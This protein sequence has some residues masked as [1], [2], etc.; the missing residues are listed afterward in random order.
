MGHREQWLSKWIKNRNYTFDTNNRRNTFLYIYYVTVKSAYGEIWAAYLTRKRNS[1]FVKPL[2]TAEL[3]RRIKKWSS[4][5]CSDRKFRNKKIFAMLGITEEEV[6]EL[7]IEK[8]KIEKEE[9]KKR[10]TKRLERNTEII[11]LRSKGKTQKEIVL[12]LNVSLS[13]VKRVLRESR[14]IFL[15]GSEF[16]ITDKIKGKSEPP[17]FRSPTAE[18]LYSLYKEEQQAAPSNEYELALDKLQHSNR[19]IFIQGV[20]GSGKSTLIKEYLSSLSKSERKTVL[21][22][23]PTGKAA[24]IIGGITI[25]KAFELPSSVQFP[26]EITTVPK[27]LHKIKT[28][29][30]DEISMVRID[31]FQKMMQIL[32]YVKETT[33]NAIRLIVVGDFGQLRPVLTSEDK[34]IFKQFYPEIK[35]YYAFSA[36]EWQEANFEKIIL[37][38]VKRQENAEFI[39]HLNGIKYGKLSDIDWFMDY[40]SPFCPPTPVY[41]CTTKKRVEEFNNKA[42]AE[43]ETFLK[44][45]TADFDGSLP[46]DLPVPVELR[47]GVG[48]RVMT[49]VNSTKYKN[50]NV[51]TVKAVTDD[52][53][54]VRFDSG[55]TATVKRHTFELDNGTTYIQFPLVLAYALTVHK[56]QGSTYKDVAIV[57]D[58]FFEAG[59]LYVALSRCTSLENLFFLGQLKKEDLKIDTESLK[60]TVYA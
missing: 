23:A 18:N 55:K 9:R 36:P 34:A 1:Y 48:V 15:K 25:H 52:S 45:Y 2:D 12:Q 42:L 7:Q 49:V 20:A 14:N 10:T 56:S 5:K 16:T 26:D 33:G 41:L 17:K 40:A 4:L 28:I 32:K 8:N 47:L 29:I 39:E 35:S 44:T 46:K 60:M 27:A 31:V 6:S 37:H 3:E 53:V 58:D 11:L 22:I 30:I 38:K 19:N 59:M 51:G 13:T 21:L 43:C 57:C 50:G 24:D 54:L